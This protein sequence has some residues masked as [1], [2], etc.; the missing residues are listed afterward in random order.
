MDKPKTPDRIYL[1]D[2]GADGLVWCDDPAPGT[3]MDADDAVEYVR[4]G[5]AQQDAPTDA[6]I[7]ETMRGHI[8]EADG[9]YACDTAEEHV[10]AAGRALLARFAPTQ[11]AER[12][13]WLESQ[14]NEHGA[15][16]LHDGN[17]PAGHGLGLRP[18]NLVRTLREAIDAA[19]A[20]RAG[21]EGA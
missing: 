1:I 8:D 12:I 4:I 19:R 20:Q 7:L 15:I 13:D 18:G 14:I 3:D 6:E 5:A 10:I 11:D 17:H 9:G 2:M 21:K 16:H